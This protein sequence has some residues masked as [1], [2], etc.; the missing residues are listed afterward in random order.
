MKKGFTINPGWQIILND[1]GVDSSN[2]LRRASLPDDFFSHEGILISTDEYFRLWEAIEVEAGDPDIAFRIGSGVSAESFDPPIFAALCS[3]DFNTAIKRIADYKVL[4]CPMKVEIR[5]T[6][7]FM[8]FELHWLE[9]D[10]IPPKVLVGVEI[11]FFVH[12]IRLAT[13]HHVNPLRVKTPHIPEN[14]KLYEEYLGTKLGKGTYPTLRFSKQ[15]ASLPFLTANHSM[16]KF[17]EPGLR[18]RLSELDAGAK[19]SERVRG[20]L[21]ELIPTGENTLQS[22]SRKLHLSTRSLQRHLKSEGVNYQTI[23]DK[24]RCDLANHYLKVSKLTGAEIAYLLGFQDP[25][26]FFRA[27]QTWTGTTPQRFRMESV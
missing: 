3:P 23:L 4:V 6:D 25:S 14:K 1:A 26:S 15:D 9:A 16:W 10:V 8:E 5:T 18:R 22:V 13:R 17:F 20:A 21:L 24:T 12:F 19:T 11:V 2:V 7:H 27:Y